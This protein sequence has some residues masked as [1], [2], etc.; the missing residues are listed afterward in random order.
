MIKF[1]KKLFTKKP[2]AFADWAKTKSGRYNYMDHNNCAYAQFLK[3]T[4]R[5]KNPSVTPWSWKD[6]N[7]EMHNI[8]DVEEFA[9]QA[10]SFEELRERLAA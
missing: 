2:T 10:R 7:G 9:L 5:A 4:G 3:E 6:D 1:F 8:S